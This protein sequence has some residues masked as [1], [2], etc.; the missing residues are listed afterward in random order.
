[1]LSLSDD[2]FVTHRLTVGPE[3]GRGVSRESNPSDS[4]EP[5]TAHIPENHFSCCQDQLQLITL[6]LHL[7][8]LWKLPLFPAAATPCLLTMLHALA[9][10]WKGELCHGLGRALLA[11]S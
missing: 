3:V 5:Y 4:P 6:G 11:L 2:T 10:T 9:Y 7:G 1:M 8:A